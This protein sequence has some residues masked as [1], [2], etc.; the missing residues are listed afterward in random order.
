[1]VFC[2]SCGTEVAQ[3]SRKGG[4]AKIWCNES[5]RGKWRYKNDPVVINKDTYS[6]QKKR[7]YKNKWNALQHKGG[8]CQEC[9]ESHPSKL[10]FH[11][12]QPEKKM[13]N[14]DGRSFANRKWETICEEVEK[15]DLLCHNCHNHLHNGLVWDQFLEQV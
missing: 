10:C 2:K 11:H 8:K 5:C 3:S 9:G 13:M 14:L 15:C 6:L 7:A 12:R 1:M 4:R